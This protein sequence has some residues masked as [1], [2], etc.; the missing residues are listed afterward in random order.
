MIKQRS[1]EPETKN[2]LENGLQRDITGNP[3]YHIKAYS[4]LNF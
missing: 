1:I 2:A 3:V 4:V